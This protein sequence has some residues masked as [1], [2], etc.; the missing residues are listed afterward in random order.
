MTHRWDEKLHECS[1]VR[2]VVEPNVRL[3]CA[4]N[5]RIEL[6]PPHRI[7]Q[8]QKVEPH[9]ALE[10]LPLRIDVLVGEHVE[11]KTDPKVKGASGPQQAVGLF[12]TVPESQC[13]GHF[14]SQLATHAGVV[15]GKLKK[16]KTK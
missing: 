9:D 2:H 12:V 7:G 3:L 6:L 15:I 13:D 10:Q 11:V 5:D 16:H 1:Q 4:L 8:S 14:A